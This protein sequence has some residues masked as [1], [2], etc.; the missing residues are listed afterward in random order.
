MTRIGFGEDLHALDRAGD[1]LW[2]G[3]VRLP[4]PFAAVAHSDGDV[5]L[6]AL[7]DAIFGALAAGD[8]GEHFPDAAPEN[9]GRASRDF[10]AAAAALMRERGY[11]IGNL[12][13]T[14]HLE[15]PRL[16]PHK[17][18]IAANIAQLL[19]VAPSAVSV[20]AKTGEGLDA[21]GRGDAVRAQVAVLLVRVES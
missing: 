13:A 4:A 11:Q 15:K 20:K 19:G 6:H 12:D 17:S 9:R 8:L 18:A 21:V 16:S 3:G 1:H 14:V 2:L 7:A 5:L 10:L